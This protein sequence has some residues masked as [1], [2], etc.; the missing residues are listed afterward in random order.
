MKAYR[1]NPDTFIYEGEQ[2]R[3][4]DPLES[5]KAGEDVFLMPAY[6]TD[7]EPPE[8]K[9]G[10]DIVWDGAAWDYTEQPKEEEPQEPEPYEQ[11]TE[12]KMAALDAQ[13]T[14]SKR[15]LQGYYLDYMLADDEEG[16]AEIKAEL[17]ALAEQYD[18]EL[19]NL[20]G[21]DA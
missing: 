2:E 11:T 9:D 16:M 20:K 13:Y 12:D 15:I 19:A 3:Q 1:Y 6:C 5:E 8:L 18:A 7:V 21:A 4:L 10:F 17:A 14:E